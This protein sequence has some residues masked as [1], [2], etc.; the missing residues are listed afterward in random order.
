MNII[1]PTKDTLDNVGIMTERI[2]RPDSELMSKVLGVL[3]NPPIQDKYFPTY[4]YTIKKYHDY[5][6]DVNKYSREKSQAVLLNRHLVGKLLYYYMYPQRCGGTFEAY[7][8]AWI[9]N[10]LCAMRQSTLKQRYN[11]GEIGSWRS[12][13]MW[14]NGHEPLVKPM[15]LRATLALAERMHDLLMPRVEYIAKRSGI[16]I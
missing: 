8:Y 6:S 13:P 1:V 5:M 11:Q 15:G 9:H 3:W 4:I 12:T 2:R 16:E 10:A 7:A 14:S